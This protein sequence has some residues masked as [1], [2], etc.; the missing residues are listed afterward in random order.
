MWFFRRY[1][2]FRQLGTV[3]IETGVVLFCVTLAVP[4]DHQSFLRALCVAFTFQW[5]LHLRDVYDLSNTLSFRVLCARLSQALL[6]ASSAVALLWYFLPTLFVDRKRLVFSLVLIILFLILWHTLLRVYARTR[7]SRSTVLVLGT[8]HLARKL[9][10]GILG[11]PQLGLKVCGFLDKEP[12]LIGTSIVNPKVLGLVTDLPRIAS[13]NNVDH[14]VV[15][16]QDRRGQ[17]PVNELLDLKFRGV[18]IEDAT[19]F[20]ERAL[21]KIPMDNLK[22]SWMIFNQGFQPS[23]LMLV[24]R[25][26]LSFV[27]S[28]TLLVV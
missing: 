8:G 7:A 28:A 2:A 11:Q 6:L 24:Q 15:E 18:A 5:S 25:W 4:P 17:L 26:I 10:K 23:R 22:P 27:I 16:L 1:L 19:T 12:S 9:V 20:Y 14:I 21:G 13:D 3:L